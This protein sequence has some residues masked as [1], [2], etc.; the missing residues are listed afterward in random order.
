MNLSLLQMLLSIL[1]L[2]A[3]ISGEKVQ[4]LVEYWL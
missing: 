3:F 2:M 1:N 4:R